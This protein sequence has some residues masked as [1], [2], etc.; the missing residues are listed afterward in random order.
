MFSQKTK[1]LY[2]AIARPFATINGFLYRHFRAPRKGQPK[3]HLGCGQNN[4]L[5]GWINVDGN[6]ISAK[7]D[8]WADLRNAFPF[9]S[10]SIDAMYSLNVLEHVPDIEHHLREAYRCLSPGGVY[11]T[12]GPNGDSAIAKFVENDAAWFS[13]FP[14][15]RTSVGGRFESMIFCRQQH[16]TILTFSFLEEIMKGVGFADVR[17]C[18][19][20]HT[21]FP[22]RFQDTLSVEPDRDPPYKL[23]I[24]AIKPIPNA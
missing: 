9:H 8:V 12:G 14:D 2:F 10:N 7:V 20:Q 13:G 23:V 16:Y 5:D 6:I 3:V 24:E 18:S 11:R 1:T 17:K 22:E 21:F 15:Q 19:M 4:Y